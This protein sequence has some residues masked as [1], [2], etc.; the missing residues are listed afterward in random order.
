MAQSHSPAAELGQL[1]LMHHVPQPDNQQQHNTPSTPPPTSPSLPPQHPFNFD[2]PTL[3]DDGS[4]SNLTTL[5]TSSPPHYPTPPAALSALGTRAVM[6]DHGYV[7]ESEGS[8]ADHY[9]MIDPDDLSEISNDD[10]DTASITSN[11]HDQDGQLTPEHAESDSDE[12]GIEEDETNTARLLDSVTVDASS[13]IRSRSPTESM[14]IVE[15]S[16][17]RQTKAENE[18]I[19]SYMS[20]DLETPRQS[21]MPLPSAGSAGRRQA[22]RGSTMTTRDAHHLLFV[23]N[24]QHP[25][26]DMD[27]I[28]SRVTAAMQ[29]GRH[30]GR[31]PSDH[32]VLRLP[33]TPAQAIAASATVVCDE[34]SVSATVQ[35]CVGAAR[36]SF[37]S[38]ALQ[39]LDHDGLNSSWAFVGP[40]GSINKHKPDLAVFHVRGYTDMACVEP[41]LEAVKAM[42]VPSLIIAE[43]M[44]WKSWQYRYEGDVYVKL[45]AVDFISM[46][47]PALTKA[48]DKVQAKYSTAKRQSN[49]SESIFSMPQ[50]F[51]LS[52]ML[53]ALP[54]IL[55]L[56]ASFLSYTPTTFDL[57]TRREA[58]SMSMA[59]VPN[60][61]AAGNG[62]NMIDLEHLL[63]ALP[64]TCY[65]KTLFGQLQR[66]EIPECQL[67]P[68][69]Q[70]L[71]PNHMLLSLPLGTKYPQPLSTTIHKSDGRD[72]RFNTTELIEGV[73]M[74]SF[75]PNETYDTV[76]I[77]M[78]TER[79]A[80]NITASHY[81]GKRFLQR[82]TYENA[83]TEVSKKVGSDL[84]IMSETVQ[85]INGL[86]SS[87][88]TASVQATRNF[89]SSLTRYMTRELQ[90]VSHE[91]Q[92]MRKTAGSM[93]VK[94]LAVI[95]QDLVKFTNGISG[96]VK[97]TVAAAKSSTKALVKS[98]LA[99]SRERL[100]GLK[101]VL[102]KRKMDAKQAP[103][104]KGIAT[105]TAR[106]R[107]VKMEKAGL[108]LEKAKQKSRCKLQERM[109]AEQQRRKQVEVPSGIAAAPAAD[110]RR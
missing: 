19:D 103:K 52:M 38:Y 60:L 91:L 24:Q 11:E 107:A 31:S 49:A 73:W 67:E 106:K 104:V 16:S 1:E 39:I 74:V 56:L 37:G 83:G 9:D 108:K 81:Y 90:V 6:A 5:P 68:R 28:V 40:D 79:P 65:E 70:P 85:K 29:S 45:K 63:P 72:V 92:L 48:I 27:L 2:F 14:V 4:V 15:S 44:V 110:Q 66:R 25:K 101:Q 23:S 62:T 20:D 13:H 88:V 33:P 57:S 78:M 95:Q 76:T 3:E 93:L 51:S 94:D 69:F 109:R 89:T 50:R 71:Q 12:D 98:P 43:E 58:L 100:H 59:K 80:Y 21:T 96:S 46:P 54:V 77:N 32:K 84:A 42:K 7:S 55:L 82:K 86:L 18:L 102:Q 26:R 99:V 97:S 35:H 75:D 41:V 22:P 17:A 87:E 47:L 105:E 30:D 36:Q 34:D 64:P 53:S 10:H 8:I 61:V